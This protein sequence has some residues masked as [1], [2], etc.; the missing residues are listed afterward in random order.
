M[1]A[2][3][4]DKAPAANTRLTTLV[5]DWLSKHPQGLSMHYHFLTIEKLAA[6]FGAETVFQ[7]FDRAFATMPVA[8]DT[9]MCVL[10]GLQLVAIN[11]QSIRALDY[12]LQ[13]KEMISPDRLSISIEAFAMEVLASASTNRADKAVHTLLAHFNWL[14]SKG[15]CRAGNLNLAAAYTCHQ[16]G[17]YELGL[18]FAYLGCSDATVRDDEHI[19]SLSKFF[20]LS[21]SRLVSGHSANLYSMHSQEIGKL[22]DGHLDLGMQVNFLWPVNT[23]S[24][25]LSAQKPDLAQVEYLLALAK[26]L[27]QSVDR[28]CWAAWETTNGC[29]QMLLGNRSKAF[30]MLERSMTQQVRTDASFNTLRHKLR[31]GLGIRYNYHELNWQPA[32]EQAWSKLQACADFQFNAAR[33]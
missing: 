5:R 12:G 11:S 6:Q 25:E 18:Q 32:S 27:G 22:Q 13:L 23:A 20:V 4:P 8:P 31:K 24:L 7:A 17:R 33:K 1:M 30:D 26:E 16:F 21:A 29:L 19:I 28:S 14:R 3:C 10:A 15:E 9:H 2:I